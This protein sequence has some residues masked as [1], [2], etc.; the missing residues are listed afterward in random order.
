MRCSPLVHAFIVLTRHANQIATGL[1]VTFLG[2][3]LTALF[4]QD[5]VGQGV[6][7]VRGRGRSR[8]CRELPFLGPILFDHDPLTYLVVP[9]WPRSRGGCCSGPASA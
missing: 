2:L 1:V 7:R 5:Y 8:A 9:R 6:E 4:G 3:G